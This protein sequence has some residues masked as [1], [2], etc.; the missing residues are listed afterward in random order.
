[1]RKS[2]TPMAKGAGKDNIK[3]QKLL[4]EIGLGRSS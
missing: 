1:M 3:A 2:Y 4:R